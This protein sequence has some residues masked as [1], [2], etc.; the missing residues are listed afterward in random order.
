M[1]G[2]YSSPVIAASNTSTPGPNLKPMA[3]PMANWCPRQVFFFL[4]PTVKRRPWYEAFAE[5]L[6]RGEIRIA[7]RLSSKH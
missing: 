6:K 5:T 7:N 1:H 4:H 2:I 3:E